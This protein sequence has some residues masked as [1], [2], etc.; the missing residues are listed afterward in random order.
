MR[1]WRPRR[2]SSSAAGCGSSGTASASSRRSPATRAGCCSPIS[3]C[4]ATVRSAATSCW[5]CC[6]PARPRRRVPTRCCPPR[7]RGCARRSG[8]GG[9]R[10]AASCRWPCRRRPGSIGK[11]RS[12]V[13][14]RRTP[15]SPHGRWQA[16]W[17]AARA[18]RWRSPR[19][20]CCRALRRAG[21][22]RSA[23][24]SADLRLELLEVV[25]ASGVRLGGAELPHAEQ[26]ARAAVEAAPFRESARAALIEVLRARGNVADALR[27]FEDART[28][29]REELGATPGPLLL[30]LH[31][32]LLRAE[33]AAAPAAAAGPPGGG[34]GDAARR[35]REPLAR[36]Q[37]ELR[38]AREGETAVVL[39][40]GEGGIGKTRLIAEVAPRR[41][42]LR[43]P[44]RALRRGPAL[45]LRPVDRDARRRAGPR[46]RR[47]PPR[48]ARRGRAGPRAPAPRAPRPRAG[49]GRARPERS[50][51]RAAPPLHR[52]RRA[53]AAP[54]PPP[55][56]A[57][58]HRRPA[59]GRPLVAA[60]RPSPRCA[61]WA[62][63]RRCC[64]APTATPS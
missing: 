2:A 31:Q 22:T 6:G 32:Q 11:W 52:R 3:S 50:R 25:A 61:R 37:A 33:P 63:G 55:P 15:P 8:P 9:W 60:A 20:A 39:V 64:S 41:G 35:P 13:C 23:P 43:R 48:A 58:D 38:R 16:A 51:E 56:A 4:I 57:G 62:S 46:R 27:A 26:A 14:A 36:L 47:G 59:L 42:G 10:A 19:A 21:S 1:A 34:A 40:T 54:G 24:S 18:R 44:L 49:A 28:L 53:G 29:L 45:P 30:R 5:R 12:A 7:S 17:D